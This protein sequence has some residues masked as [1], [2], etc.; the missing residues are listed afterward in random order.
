MIARPSHWFKNVFMLP[1]TLIAA[2]FT[3]T[4]ADLIVWPLFIGIL[5]TSL[6][7]SANYVINELLD[8]EFD[9]FHPTKKDRPLVSG[10]FYPPYI[11]IEY[12]ILASVGLGLAYLISGLFL[13]TSSFFLLMGIFYNVKPF[14]TKDRAYFDVISESINN[15][16]RLMLG[17]LIVTS[18]PLPPSSL[19]F[20]YWM[21]GAFL[22][23]I[24]RYG[25]KGRC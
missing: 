23:A 7:A 17:W 22:M 19:I 9:S 6:I 12:I 14:R 8:L 5:S 21:G 3:H 4:P 18:Y 2:I 10:D 24:K 15:P 11:Y 13:L 20:G 1:G 16:I 25:W